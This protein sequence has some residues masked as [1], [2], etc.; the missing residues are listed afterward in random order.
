[1]S[2][3][4]AVDLHG[5]ALGLVVQVATEEG[6]EVVHLGLE[7]LR[8]GSALGG[9][10]TGAS[11]VS[12]DLLLLGVGDCLGEGGESIAHLGS[13][14]A[15]GSVLESLGGI[16]SVFHWQVG[17]GYNCGPCWV[18]LHEAVVK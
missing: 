15:G 16:S 5:V 13:G 9:S 6:E 11:I 1:M 18:G 4:S 7:E 12:T 14:D 2:F 10:C 8:Q 17:F 3:F